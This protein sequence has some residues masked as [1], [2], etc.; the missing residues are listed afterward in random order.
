[1]P[2]SRSPSLDESMSSAGHAMATVQSVG[3]VTKVLLLLQSS[4][5]IPSRIRRWMLQLAGVRA[6]RGAVVRPGTFFGGPRVHLGV[7]VFVNVGGFFDGCAPITVGD[8]TRVGPFARILTGTH[9]YR[10]SVIR[11]WPGDPV[12]ARPVAIERGCWIGM[13]SCILPGVTI[14]EGCVIAAGSVVV[15]STEPNGLYAGNPAR[16]IKDL[17]TEEGLPPEVLVG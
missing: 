12:V 8:F 11:R 3:L 1:M 14:A 2:T 15:R 13:G 17:G 6:A 10:S 16:R 5:W 7:G 4:F 9:S